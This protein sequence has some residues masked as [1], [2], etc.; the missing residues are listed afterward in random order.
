MEEHGL[1]LRFAAGSAR[2]LGSALIALCALASSSCALGSEPPTPGASGGATG[3]MAVSHDRSG[4]QQLTGDRRVVFPLTVARTG[5]VAGFDD[6]LELEADGRVHVDSRGVQGRVCFLTPAQQ[7][8][9][10]LL[11][12]SPLGQESA[13]PTRPA[14]LQGSPPDNEGEQDGPLVV[15]VTDGQ[16]RAVDLDHSSSAEAYDL[17]EALLGDVTLSN[18]TSTRCSTT[19]P[20]MRTTQPSAGTVTSKG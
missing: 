19:P 6:H 4:L 17:L 5:G 2:R 1:L 8:L 11:A 15:T 18:P 13:R 3:R 7:R 14:S 16:S 10:T 9:L 20:A 12:I